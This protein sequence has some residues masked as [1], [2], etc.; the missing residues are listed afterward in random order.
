MLNE[1]QFHLQINVNVQIINAL[2]HSKK[3]ILIFTKKCTYI[4]QLSGH[5]IQ[6]K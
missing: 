1:E 5:K 3:I 6:H 2:G 4:L